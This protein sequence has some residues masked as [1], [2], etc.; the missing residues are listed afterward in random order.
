[1]KTH[2]QRLK[3]ETLRLSNIPSMRHLSLVP[4]ATTRMGCE[5]Q[6]TEVPFGVTTVLVSHALPQSTSAAKYDNG[7]TNDT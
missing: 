7:V 5:D 6:A 4:Y 1:M 3:D 2:I